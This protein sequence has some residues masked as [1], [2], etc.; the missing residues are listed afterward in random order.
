MF[1]FIAHTQGWRLILFPLESTVSKRDVIGGSVTVESDGVIT[2]HTGTM[3]GPVDVAIEMYEQPP[4]GSIDDW[5]DVVE[6]SARATDT[7][8]V[9]LVGM[10]SEGEDSDGEDPDAVTVRLGVCWLF[11]A[12][13][14]VG[15]GASVPG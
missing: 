9:G 5:D 13:S 2:I 12:E 10:F 4:S 6:V 8:P 1:K 3:Y 14:V 11:A 15:L 7:G